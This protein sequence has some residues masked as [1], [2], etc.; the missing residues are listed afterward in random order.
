MLRLNSI[1]IQRK[2]VY[3]TYIFYDCLIELVR[4]KFHVQELRQEINATNIS[5]INLIGI[6]S[7]KENL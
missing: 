1:Y 4:H 3:L 6:I 5:C 2:R 7:L